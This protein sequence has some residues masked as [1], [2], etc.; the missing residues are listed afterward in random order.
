MSTRANGR[1]LRYVVCVRRST[2]V[3]PSA[4]LGGIASYRECAVCS[5]DGDYP[6]ERVTVAL[7]LRDIY[8]ANKED[9][10]NLVLLLSN[11]CFA[12]LFGTPSE[13]PAEVNLFLG[14][15]DASS[16]PPSV[17]WISIPPAPGIRVMMYRFNV[18]TLIDP[19][20]ELGVRDYRPDAWAAK[21][22]YNQN[23]YIPIPA[24]ANGTCRDR[25]VTAL[26]QQVA[27]APENV[28][29]H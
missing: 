7:T 25:I 2:K 26:T 4:L 3:A 27:G 17:G 10:D 9:F 18:K 5:S 11:C 6:K 21:S 8:D 14:F 22:C 19:P 16:Q 20:N 1:I 24:P 13:I 28:L 29:G 12:M 15:S 23:I